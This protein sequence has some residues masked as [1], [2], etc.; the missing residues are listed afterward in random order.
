MIKKYNRDLD[1][2]KTIDEEY[3]DDGIL[4]GGRALDVL[5][6]NRW[7]LQ[8]PVSIQLRWSSNSG[9]VIKKGFNFLCPEDLFVGTFKPPS[10][11]PQPASSR[12]TSP[13]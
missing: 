3:K 1:V 7:S 8:V 11:P 10:R 12:P 6:M 9:S 4:E 5:N 13:R 2:I